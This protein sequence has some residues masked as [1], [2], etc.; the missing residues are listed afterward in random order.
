MPIYLTCRRATGSNRTCSRAT[1]LHTSID[2]R[3]CALYASSSTWIRSTTSLQAVEVATKILEYIKRC[4]QLHPVPNFA[5]FFR[6][7]TSIND[8]QHLQCKLSELMLEYEIGFGIPK[9][10]TYLHGHSTF[11]WNFLSRAMHSSCHLVME[12]YHCHMNWSAET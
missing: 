11:P 8:S 1:K 3:I 9:S 12:T 2:S 10:I 7:L 4:Q 5:N 6:S